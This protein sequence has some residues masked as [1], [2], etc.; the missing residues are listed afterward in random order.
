[1][2]CLKRV[3]IGMLL[4]AA[5]AA[6]GDEPGLGRGRKE[7]SVSGALF[8]PNR[9]VADTAGVISG[10]FGYY[11]AR[12]S[13]VGVDSTLLVFSRTT[14]V[15]AAGYYRFVMLRE[16]RRLV[17][18]VGGAAGSNVTSFYYW[19]GTEHRLLVKGEAGLRIRVAPRTG[20]DLA[21]NL[22]YLR[23]AGSGFVQTTTSVVSF[24]FSHAF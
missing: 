9:T 14:T 6:A 8:A 19:G 22:M 24:G 5:A 3:V 13:Q 11:L 21:Y 20:F 16:G 15:Y 23:G 7:F 2:F 10:R 4:C 18:F 1:V 17:P 12:H